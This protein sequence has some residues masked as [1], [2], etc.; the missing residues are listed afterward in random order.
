MGMTEFSIIHFVSMEEEM[1]KFSL[2]NTKTK[3][4]SCFFDVNLLY[5]DLLLL[6]NVSDL[7]AC[8]EI[9]NIIAKEIGFLLGIF[10]RFRCL[11]EIIKSPF[12]IPLNIFIGCYTLSIGAFHDWRSRKLDISNFCCLM[13]LLR[14]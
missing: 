12:N 4:T 2:N 3:L 5:I 13:D 7:K 8:L 9:S 10:Y 14:A 1:Y 6:R 11:K